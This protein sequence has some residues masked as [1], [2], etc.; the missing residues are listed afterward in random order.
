MNQG[1][2]SLAVFALVVERGSFAAAAARLERAPSA[3]S[4]HIRRLEQWFGERLLQRTTRRMA[5]TPAGERL[6]PEAQAVLAAH[7]RAQALR[8]SM[9]ET[10]EGPLRISAP[11]ALLA[12]WIIPAIA[13][14]R[15]THPQVQI[16]LEATDRRS[17]LQEGPMVVALRVG[18]LTTLGLRARRVGTLQEARVSQPG[19]PDC[20]IRLP[21]Q[22][23][24]P[25]TAE[26]RMDSVVAAR[27]AVDAGLGW[28][29]LPVAEGGDI[30]TPVYAVHG[31]GS[32]ASKAVLAF[33]D[34]LATQELGRAKHRQ[35]LS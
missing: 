18:P 23:P 32:Q 13:R 21:W 2:H 9:A 29:V 24:R 19:A 30:E 31:F 27:A 15:Q 17:E 28:A 14:M 10:V 22:S 5:L 25:A 1:L 20:W 35:V 4:G 12:D 8:E 33:I 34:I 7:R 16:S 3:V 11:T 26:I 6:L